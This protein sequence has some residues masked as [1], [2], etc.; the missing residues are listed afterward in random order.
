VLSDNRTDLKL[1][2]FPQSLSFVMVKASFNEDR[3]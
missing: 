1:R 3:Y 2:T